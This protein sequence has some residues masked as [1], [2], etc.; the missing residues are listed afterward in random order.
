MHFFYP[1]T[2]KKPYFSY[3]DYNKIAQDKGTTKQSKQNKLKI[4]KNSYWAY[5]M[6]D[7]NKISR[8]I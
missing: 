2:D 8:H 7:S 1:D 6:Y 5:F 4:L 3:C